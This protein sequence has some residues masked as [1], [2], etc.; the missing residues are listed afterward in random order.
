M[1]PRGLPRFKQNVSIQMIDHIKPNWNTEDFYN[2]DYILATHKDEEL[3]DQYLKS[4]HSKEKQSP[5]FHLQCA[6]SLICKI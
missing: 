4:G 3:V 1:E 2:L 6:I 5:A